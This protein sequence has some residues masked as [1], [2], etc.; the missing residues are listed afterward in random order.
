KKKKGFTAINIIGL[1]IGMA[2]AMLIM[3]WVN[4]ELSYDRFYSNSKNIYAVGNTDKWGADS[5]MWFLT[6]KPIAEA[7]KTEYPEISNVTRVE[8]HSGFMLSTGSKK[9][10]SE[11]GGFVDSTFLEMFDFKVLAGNAKRAL[12]DPSQI[13]VTRSLADRLFAAENPIGSTLKIDA[14]DIFT[15]GAVLEDIPENSFMNGTTYLLPWRYLENLGWSDN[16]WTNN[17]VQT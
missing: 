8:P 3:I 4:S 5:A 7:L 6:P 17:S 15:V 13:V 2:S 12:R 11:M 9:L 14:S 1:A 10:S 16:Y